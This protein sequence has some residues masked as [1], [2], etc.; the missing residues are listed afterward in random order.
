MN[1]GHI[2]CAG[3][4]LKFL[5]AVYS[6][7]SVPFRAVEVDQRYFAQNP[8]LEITGRCGGGRRR[9]GCRP[10]LPVLATLH[11]VEGQP[12]LMS[13]PGDLAEIG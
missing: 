11:Q 5:D 9:G 3:Q 13:C 4:G 6:A 10:V 12:G 2:V 1:R 7:V 8:G